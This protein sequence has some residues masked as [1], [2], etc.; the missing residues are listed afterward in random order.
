MVEGPE[1]TKLATGSV[2]GVRRKDRVGGREAPKPAAVLA[3]P[4]FDKRDE[5]VIG[6]TGAGLSRRKVISESTDEIISVS[7]GRLS[8]SVADAGLLARGAAYLPRLPFSR[9]E[10]EAI[11]AVTPAGEGM[12]AVDFSASRKTAM[13]PQLAQYRIVHFATH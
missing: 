13:G 10:A 11:L 12:Q 6:K 9:R 4:V 5:R 3:D 1:I 8:R 2:L 7:A